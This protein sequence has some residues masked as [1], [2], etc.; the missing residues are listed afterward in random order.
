M[1]K[2]LLSEAHL[3]DMGSIPIRGNVSTEHLEA[4]MG[5]GLSGK[6]WY[7]IKYNRLQRIRTELAKAG[8]QSIYKNGAVALFDEHHT[9]LGGGFNIRFTSPTYASNGESAAFLLVTVIEPVSENRFEY[10][11]QYAGGPKY[12]G[13]AD[14]GLDHIKRTIWY[15]AIH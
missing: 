2:A 5:A 14:D 10:G 8:I 4:V 11:Y 3:L 15:G 1:L 12:H 13:S 7:R 6:Q 9:A